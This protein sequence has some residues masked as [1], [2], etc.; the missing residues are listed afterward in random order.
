MFHTLKALE[1]Y[2]EVIVLCFVKPGEA[3][4]WSVLCKPYMLYHTVFNRLDHV[5]SLLNE[6]IILQIRVAVLEVGGI[7]E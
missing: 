2:I 4:T 5:I 3:T 7:P 6:E 1:Q